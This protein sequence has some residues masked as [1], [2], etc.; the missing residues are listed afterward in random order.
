MGV[1][2]KEEKSA[3]DRFGRFDGERVFWTIEE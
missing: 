2:G 3:K 1:N